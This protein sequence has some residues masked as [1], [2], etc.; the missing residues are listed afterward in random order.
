MAIDHA[1]KFI[2]RIQTDSVFRNRMYEFDA[3]EARDE[4]LKSEGYTFDYDEFENAF[5]QK[6]LKSRDEYEANGYKE[7]LLWWQFLSV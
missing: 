7:I 2:E 5:R 1:L 4:Y 3:Q 6:L